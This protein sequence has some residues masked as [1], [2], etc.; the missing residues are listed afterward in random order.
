[1]ARSI[2]VKDR[3]YYAA[4]AKIDVE[5][6]TPKTFKGG[7]DI[8]ELGKPVPDQ[9]GADYY[10]PFALHYRNPTKPKL[11]Q[12]TGEAIKFAHWRE[13]VPTQLPRLFNTAIPISLRYFLPPLFM[14]AGGTLSQGDRMANLSREPLPT[15]FPAKTGMRDGAN[16]SQAELHNRLPVKIAACL[17]L[18]LG[19]VR[20]QTVPQVVGPGE[21][22]QVSVN[23][24]SHVMSWFR[25]S[26]FYIVDEELEPM[27]FE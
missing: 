14:P 23:T 9:A 12:L 10:Y 27:K 5:V 3:E 15:Q 13:P 26:N 1:M 19:A 21:K 4:P 25:V 8:L 6:G 17:E 16:I 11:V 18:N 24:E 2:E 22:L 20:Y 7:K